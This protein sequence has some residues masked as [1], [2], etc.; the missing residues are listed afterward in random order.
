MDNQKTVER[1][2]FF[3]FRV[4]EAGKLITK[5]WELSKRTVLVKGIQLSS[6]YYEKLFLRG[7]QKIEI[8]GEEIISEGFV[9][10]ALLSTGNVSPFKRFFPFKAVQPGDLSFKLR[11]QDNDHPRAPFENGYDIHVLLITD[12]KA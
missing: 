12:E 10:R 5:D 4:E 1:Y 9:S 3:S 2:P 7:T 11:F 6:S 8:G